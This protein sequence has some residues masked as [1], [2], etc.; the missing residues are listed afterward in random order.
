VLLI[1]R[2]TDLK[3]GRLLVQAV[4]LAAATLRRPLTLVVAG[5]G[6]ERAAL[7]ELARRQQVPAEF[8]GWVGAA[9]RAELMRAADVLAVPSVWPEPF[10]LVGIEA[11]C[12]GLPAVAYAV[13]GIPDWLVPGRSGELA[14]GGPPTARGLAQALHRALADSAHLARLR[15]GAWEMARHYSQQRHVAALEAALEQA[16]APALP[17]PVAAAQ[18]AGGAAG[19]REG[20]DG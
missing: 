14:P 13:G 17:S 15:A 11:G 19:R 1:G 10:G 2:L 8:V 20:W 9:R 12:V 4:R 16:A 3:G 6:P 18:G 5:D 7:E